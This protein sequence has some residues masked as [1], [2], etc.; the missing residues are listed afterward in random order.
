MQ[1]IGE[2]ECFAPGHRLNQMFVKEILKDKNNYTIEKAMITDDPENI[3][4]VLDKN[5]STHNI[6]NVA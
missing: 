1:L 2:V 6:T 5:S 4:N 3:Y